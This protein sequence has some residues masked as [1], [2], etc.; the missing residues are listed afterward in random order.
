MND[1]VEKVVK[2]IEIFEKDPVVFGS[3]GVSL[4][5]G[6]FKDFNDIDILI[7]QELLD[8]RWDELKSF[9]VSSGWTL[10][11]KKE[12]EFIISGQKVGFAAKQILIRDK[13]IKDFSEL[14][15]FKKTGALTLSPEGYLRNY[16]YSR[17]DGYRIKNRGKKD[18]LIISRLRKY[19]NDT[20]GL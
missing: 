9:L 6:K 5:L 15:P 11:D 10:F 4:Y 19:L 20:T 12:H 18:D 14:V 1:F 13:I 8:D 16:E 7:D 17:K 3:H 2:A